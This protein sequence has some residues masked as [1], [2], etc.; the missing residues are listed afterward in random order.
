MTSS[1]E[2]VETSLCTSCAI[3]A[4]YKNFFISASY[5]LGSI[6]RY[7]NVMSIHNWRFLF[8]VAIPSSAVCIKLNNP[9]ANPSLL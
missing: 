8:E 7:Q 2:S 4:E 9:A 1:R 3:W 5:S 6:C